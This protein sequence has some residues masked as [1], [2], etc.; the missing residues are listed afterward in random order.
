MSKPPPAPP[1]APGDRVRIT[2]DAF[3]DSP[4]AHPL[5][6]AVGVVNYVWNIFGAP[7]ISITVEPT[8]EYQR[9]RRALCYYHEV[10]KEQTDATVE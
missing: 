5:R 10:V 4:L 6:G 7:M 2:A 3:Q 1:V 9:S 8:S